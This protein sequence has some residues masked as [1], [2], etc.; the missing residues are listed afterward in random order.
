[1]AAGP[2]NDKPL[3]WLHGAITTPPFST[4][5]RREAGGLLRMLQGGEVLSM[6]H[7]RPMPSI[8]ARC[9]ELRVRDAGGSWRVIY[10]IDTEEIVIVEVFRKKTQQTPQQVIETCKERLK[11]FDAA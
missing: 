6:P 1:M 3:R 5:A 8:G 4:E 7:S 2:A 11:R 9:H 10:R